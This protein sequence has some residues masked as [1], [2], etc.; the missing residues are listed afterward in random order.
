[1][2]PTTQSTPVR[3]DRSEKPIL[4]VEDLHVSFRTRGTD[5]HA[6]NGIDLTVHSGETLAILGESGSGKSASAQAIM[7]IIDTP[8]GFVTGGSV[9]FHGADLLG[10]AEHERRAVRGPGIAMVFQDALAALNPVHT[11]GAQIAEMFRAHLRTPR[12]DALERAV[13]LL[14]RVGI[15]DPAR[16]ARTYPHQF[17]GGMRQRVMVAMAIALDPDVLIADEPTTALDV[18]VQAQ[19]MELLSEIQD[20]TGMGLLLITHDL[21][22]VNETADRVAVMY[23]GRIVEQGRTADVLTRPAHPYTAGLMESV[24]RAERVADRLHP[25]TGA[26]PNLAAIPAGCAFHPRCPVARLEPTDESEAICTTEHPALQLID[27]NRSAA[28]HYSAEVRRA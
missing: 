25:I 10:L 8:P 3:A 9:R 7:G 22:V 16:R 24:P 21:G 23:A 19:I 28:C 26:P 2:S 11:V 18:T 14:D 4:E 15:P 5:V 17:S 27:G 1:M 13:E 20:D 12:K 6:V